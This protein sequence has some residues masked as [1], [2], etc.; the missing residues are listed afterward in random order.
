MQTLD[1]TLVRPLPQAQRARSS[2]LQLSSRCILL[3]NWQHRAAERAT[4]AAMNQR[5]LRDIGLAR[6]E[7]L[8]EADK[9]F[10]R[11]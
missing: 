5:E 8:V 10:W 1:S 11:A 3:L 7:V 9:P 6:N 4:L 2:A